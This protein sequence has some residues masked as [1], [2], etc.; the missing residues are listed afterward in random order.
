[1]E[2]KILKDEKN[3]IEVSIDS[4][5]IAEILRDYLNKDSSVNFAA[6]KR[7]HPN[8]P[9]ILRVETK[10]KSAKKAIEDAIEDI[11]KDADKLVA[12]VKKQ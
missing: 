4:L 9:L 6:W 8:K 10:G 3:E 11:Q 2:V 12:E 7:E 1:M 5:T